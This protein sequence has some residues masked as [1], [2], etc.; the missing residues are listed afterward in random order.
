[1]EITFDSK[2]K[3]ACLALVIVLLKFRR[4]NIMMMNMNWALLTT[5]Q[6][7]RELNGSFQ[8]INNIF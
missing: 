2:M 4:K 6:D 3:R 1:M 8:V 7:V 5:S